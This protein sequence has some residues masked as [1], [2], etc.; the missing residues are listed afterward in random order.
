MKDEKIVG[1][2]GGP[3]TPVNPLDPEA[4]KKQIADWRA[5]GLQG[6]GSV[7]DSSCTAFHIH[8]KHP[9]LIGVE[10]VITVSLADFMAML[11]PAI[12]NVIVPM[13]LG[14]VR[15]EAAKPDKKV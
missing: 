6:D 14:Q 8:G 7:F 9:T 10:A 12:H 2:I 15:L 13:L 11:S 1:S 3:A 4:I 5:K